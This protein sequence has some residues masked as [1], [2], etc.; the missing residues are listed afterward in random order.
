MSIKNFFIVYIVNIE[1]GCKTLTL[2]IVKYQLEHFPVKI[3]VL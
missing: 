2:N 3:E 1:K